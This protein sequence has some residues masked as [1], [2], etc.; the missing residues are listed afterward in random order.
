HTPVDPKDNTP[1]TPVDPEDPNKGYVPPTPSNTGEDTPIPYVQNGNVVVN[2]VTE[3]GTVIK[4]PVQDETNVPAGKSYD[5]TDNKPVEIVTEDGSRYVLIP[6]K[7]VG[8]ETGT[9]EGGKTIE[10]TYVYKKVANW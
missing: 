10:I 1:L 8:S 6:S 7:T 3:D 2:Y 4:A 5:T 9:V